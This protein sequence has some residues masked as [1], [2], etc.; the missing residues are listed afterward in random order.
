MLEADQSSPSSRYRYQSVVADPGLT[1]LRRSRLG[2]AD[3]GFA[4]QGF[5][6]LGFAE[7]G[8]ELLNIGSSSVGIA[9]RAP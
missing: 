2:I 5:A 8:S 1:G 7:L 6:K 4:D 3:L 9:G